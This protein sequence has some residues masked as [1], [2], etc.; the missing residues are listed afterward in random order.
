MSD[1]SSSHVILSRVP[2]HMSRLVVP[3][4][5]TNS[6]AHGTRPPQS[7]LDNC[8]PYCSVTWTVFRSMRAALLVMTDPDTVTSWPTVHLGGSSS[9]PDICDTQ[10]HTDKHKPQPQPK[11][12]V[13]LGKHGFCT[14][15][16]HMAGFG[17][18]WLG[19]L[20]QSPCLPSQLPNAAQRVHR[21]T[22]PTC[23]KPITD[24]N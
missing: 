2:Y 16:M 18:A 1:Q 15:V 13:D 10:Q 21:C 12:E 14:R 11:C 19:K 24:P 23:T 6:T 7:S 22:E 17:M 9:S 20:V 4:I 5:N 3:A 8:S